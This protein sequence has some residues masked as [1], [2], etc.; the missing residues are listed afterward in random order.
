MSR[1]T[2]HISTTW[3]GMDDLQYFLKCDAHPGRE[4]YVVS[5]PVSCADKDAGICPKQEPNNRAA[6][7]A[8]LLAFRR[9]SHPVQ[10]CQY[11]LGTF[12]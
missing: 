4:N 12:L 9:S 5:C 7:E 6:A 11:I 3:I 10:A 2:V 1:N 8:T